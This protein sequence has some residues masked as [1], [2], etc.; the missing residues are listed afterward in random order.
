MKERISEDMQETVNGAMKDINEA[1]KYIDAIGM[2]DDEIIESIDDFRSNKKNSKRKENST[3]KATI[4]S[5]IKWS[6]L[7][8][9]CIV[10]LVPYIV[11]IAGICS[12]K[13]YSSLNGYLGSELDYSEGEK[14]ASSEQVTE[15]DEYDNSAEP[16]KDETATKVDTNN[17]LYPDKDESYAAHNLVYAQYPVMPQYP[18]RSDEY[19]GEDE[20]YSEW[21]DSL[22]QIRKYKKVDLDLFAKDSVNQIFTNYKGDNPVCSPANIYMALSVLA[23]STSGTTQEEILDALG[24]E[25]IDK[26]RKKANNLWLQCYQDDGARKSVMSN[27]IWLN[28]CQNY[29]MDTLNCLSQDYRT[30]VFN[31]DMTDSAY[32]DALRTWT[33]LHTNNV[34]QDSVNEMEFGQEEVMKIVSTIYFSAKWQNTF[35]ENETS[36]QIFHGDK[37]DSKV[38]F[39]NQTFINGCIKTEDFCKTTLFFDSAGSMDLILPDDDADIYEI[40]GKGEYLD[41]K[42]KEAVNAKVILSIPKFDVKSDINIKDALCSIGIKRVFDSQKAD[43]SNIMPTENAY[44]SD[45]NHVAGVKIDEEGCEAAAYTVIIADGALEVTETIEMKL[46]RPFIYVIRSLTGVP[47]FVG[48]VNNL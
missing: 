12:D 38:E 17:V 23:E 2:I 40:I 8:A 30:S 16:D 10:F 44:V 14:K 25:S 1:E 43:F 31:G 46:D 37:E 27:S 32:A 21:W 5:I 24:I 47:L 4:S 29:N 6:G 41:E 18:D 22:A 7:T 28:N 13:Y 26:L 19:G 39:M 42:N 15:K 36:E 35:D 34:L 20:E 45:I 48:I 3:R 9:A 11:Y 33:N